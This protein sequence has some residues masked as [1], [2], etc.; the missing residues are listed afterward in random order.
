MSD[1]PAC[2]AGWKSID[3]SHGPECPK[4]LLE[5][6]MATPDGV[7]VRR[8]FRILNA[9]H[10]GLTITLTDITEEEFRVLELIE[11]ERQEQIKN[12]DGGTGRS[13]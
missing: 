7:L 5:E 10:M 11:A 13:R 8:C 4:N 9:K 6:A 3:V 2:G 1:C 12:G